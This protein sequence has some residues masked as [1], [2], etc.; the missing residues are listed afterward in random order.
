MNSCYQIRPHNQRGLPVFKRTFLS[1]AIATAAVS[2]V[3]AA[4]IDDTVA[5]FV[6]AEENPYYDIN[7]FDTVALPDGR[8]AVV[9][10]ERREDESFLRLQRYTK[11]GQSSGPVL[12]LYNDEDDSWTPVIATD[13][14]GNM[15]VAWAVYKGFSNP[16]VL[17][18]SRVSAANGIQPVATSQMPVT[19]G[20][21]TE[22]WIS[23]QDVFHLDI[24]TDAD[25]D[26]AL[27]WS[28]QKNNY[29]TEIN[30]QTYLANGTKVT[31]DPIVSMETEYLGAVSMPLNNRVLV[32]WT[33]ANGD[34]SKL[35]LY[36]QPF[37]LSG[38]ELNTAFRLDNGN[39][40]ESDK[41]SQLLPD[42]VADGD[43][44]F[45]AA[46]MEIDYNG[47]FHRPDNV[48]IRGQRWFADG[49]AGDALSFGSEDMSEVS[50]STSATTP[51]LGTDSDG[52]LLAVWAQDYDNDPSVAQ[53]TAIDGNGDFIGEPQ[54]NYGEITKSLLGRDNYDGGRVAMSDDLVA[55]VWTKDSMTLQARVMPGLVEPS[56]DTDGSGGSGS[57][58]S[59]SGGSGSPLQWLLAGL[60]VIVRRFLAVK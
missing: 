15:V 14:D 48:A 24:A 9:W 4:L 5:E 7:G 59:G 32:S 51:Q 10:V 44:G 54:F 60:L 53:A 6:I 56:D 16:I 11:T 8:F 50:G 25:G 18:A 49:S 21:G 22:Y 55:I 46:W 36:G 13:D 30:V 28:Q 34:G 31:S 38:T 39:S 23:E 17:M 47:N 29:N 2:P 52:N 41:L 20:S 42:L 57:S 19:P 12:T 43:G 27:L 35:L 33:E 1:V 58:S 26:F 3:S 37:S 45:A 40:I